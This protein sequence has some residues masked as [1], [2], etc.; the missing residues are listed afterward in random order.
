MMQVF[1]SPYK[2][3]NKK[4]LIFQEKIVWAKNMRMKE[5]GMPKKVLKRIR[6]WKAK[7]K[8]EGSRSGRT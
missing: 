6:K 5:I 3:H 1:V 7:N 8:I 4:F 2:V